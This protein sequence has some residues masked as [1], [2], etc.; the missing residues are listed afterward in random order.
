[1]REI[2]FRAWDKVAKAMYHQDHEA[3]YRL[4]YG[5]LAFSLW[6]ESE[7]RRWEIETEDLEV[8]QYSGLNDKNGKEIYEGDVVSYQACLIPILKE[9][10]EV[11]YQANSFQFK[12]PGESLAEVGYLSPAKLTVMGNIYETR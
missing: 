8:M 9:T 3:F 12:R 2:K 10:Y 7:A 4:E 11:V 6:G 1:M 5:D